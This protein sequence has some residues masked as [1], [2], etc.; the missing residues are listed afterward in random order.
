MCLWLCN[1]HR[2]HQCHIRQLYH[3]YDFSVAIITS[4]NHHRL[5]T[6]ATILI[7]IKIIMLLVNALMNATILITPSSV[8][9]SLLSSG[10]SRQ[11]LLRFR[12]S[13]LTNAAGD[14][15]CCLHQQQVCDSS[16]VIVGCSHMTND[17]HQR[18]VI[19]R[20][21]SSPLAVFS[22]ECLVSYVSPHGGREGEGGGASL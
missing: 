17:Q 3:R 11:R 18:C 20:V 7:I 4:T 5:A 2:D 16:T 6:T 13:L 22:V 10:L 14:D 9:S 1:F 21:S 19:F 15:P 8:T 12:C